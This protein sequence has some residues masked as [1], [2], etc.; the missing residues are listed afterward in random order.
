MR[1]IIAIDR[2]YGSGGRE[3]GQKIAEHYGINYYDSALLAKVAQ[4]S[5]FCKEF[6]EQ[7]DEKASGS[8]LYNLVM[9]TYSFGYTS[10]SFGEMPVSQQIFLAQFDTIRKIAKEESGAVI[11][12]RCAD[13]ALQ[14]DPRLISVFVHASEEF[15]LARAADYPDIPEASKASPERLRDFVGKKDKQRQSYYNYYSMKKWGRADT[16]NL[17]LDTG[18]LG[19]DGSV[20]LLTQLIDDF[21]NKTAQ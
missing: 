4:E 18:F 3:V 1:S 5:G 14:D 15:R 20:R 16:Y 21:E 7:Q 17:T 6:V 12:G 10:G 2:Q 11:I 8:F 19:I 9:D 13:C